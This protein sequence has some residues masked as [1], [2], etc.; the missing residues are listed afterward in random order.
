M[1]YLQNTEDNKTH[2]TRSLPPPGYARRWYI[3]KFFLWEIS[4]IEHRGVNHNGLYAKYA[5]GVNLPLN[6]VPDNTLYCVS[7]S[8]AKHT[9]RLKRTQR[10]QSIPLCVVNR[11]A[12]PKYV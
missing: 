9:S 7:I 8:F 1:K 5:N 3:I 10:M 4:N 6:K 11:S 2:T 12:E